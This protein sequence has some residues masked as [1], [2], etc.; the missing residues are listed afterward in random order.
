MH[1]ILNVSNNYNYACIILLC[2]LHGD[3][4]N[5]MYISTDPYSYNRAIT[6]VGYF[7]K[8]MWIFTL[9]YH[10]AS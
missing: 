5:C 2:F 10:V 1:A 3:I 8:I 4:A 9:V 7:L 6:I